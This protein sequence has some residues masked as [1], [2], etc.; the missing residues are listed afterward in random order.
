MTTVAQSPPEGVC[1]GVCVYMWRRGWG[2]RGSLR[3]CRHVSPITTTTPPPPAFFFSLHHWPP[4]SA[5]RIKI[6]FGNNFFFFLKKS[7]NDSRESATRRIRS[8]FSFITELVIGR[9]AG[10]RGTPPGGSSPPNPRR[11]FP[12]F[13]AGQRYSF[14]LFLAFNSRRCL[15]FFIYLFT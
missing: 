1:V 11:S 10:L 6:H 3:L 13:F 15:K 2:A 5:G 4:R 7:E 9:E 12:S 8:P 14:F